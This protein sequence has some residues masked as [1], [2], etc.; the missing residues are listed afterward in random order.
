[1][2]WAIPCLWTNCLLR[3]SVFLLS[4]RDAH[5]NTLFT[6]LYI[7]LQCQRTEGTPLM[8]PPLFVDVCYYTCVIR[9]DQHLFCSEP[10][11]CFREQITALSSSMLVYLDHVG[12]CFV[13]T[14][15][16]IHVFP[17]HPCSDTVIRTT[18]VSGV[19]N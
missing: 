6:G 4:R 14:T 8:S 3:N 2:L 19:L 12:T 13:P 11:H 9:L 17:L 10:A 18:N 5:I 1:M 7:E 15:V 16:F